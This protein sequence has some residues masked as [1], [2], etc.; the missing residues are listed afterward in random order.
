MT[1][2]CQKIGE[3]VPVDLMSKPPHFFKIILADTLRQGKL[4]RFLSSLSLGENHMLNNVDL[5]LF[6]VLENLYFGDD[7]VQANW[8]IDAM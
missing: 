4:V 5:V 3:Y 6:V 2:Q 1:F 7:H 8:W